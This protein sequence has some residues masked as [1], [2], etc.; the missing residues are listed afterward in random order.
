MAPPTWAPVRNVFLA[1][2]ATAGEVWTRLAIAL[3][4]AVVAMRTGSA[5]GEWM[6]RIRR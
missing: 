1:T 6:Q 3:A 5:W 4:V 2:E